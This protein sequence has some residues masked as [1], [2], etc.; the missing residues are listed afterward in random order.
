MWND[1]HVNYPLFLLDFNE[2]WIFLTDFPENL[3]KLCPVG[4]KLFHADGQMD[5]MKLIVT[6]HTFANVPKK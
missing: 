6:F 4:V 5:M 1:V 2:T 3:I